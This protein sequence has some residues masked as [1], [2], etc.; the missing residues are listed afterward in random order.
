M[1]A[2]Q[3]YVTP[4]FFDG[5]CPYPVAA[6]W[7]DGA[8]FDTYPCGIVRKRVKWLPLWLPFNAR[9][10]FSIYAQLACVKRLREL[11]EELRTHMHGAIRRDVECHA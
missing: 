6:L 3:V 11:G 7:I 1:E 8:L 9:Y 2:V 10:D 5:T 4:E